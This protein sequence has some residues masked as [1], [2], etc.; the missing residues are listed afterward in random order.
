MDTPAILINQQIMENNLVRMAEKVARTETIQLRPHIKTHKNPEIAKSQLA[1]GA[2]G[3]TVAK[4]GEAEVMIDGGIQDVFLAYPLVSTEKITRGLDLAKRVQRF[5]FS[6]DTV[7]GAERLNYLA[8]VAGILAEVRL[9]INTGLARTGVELGEAVK[10]AEFLGNLK[11][12]KLSGIYTYRGSK[13]LDGEA[14]KDT[15]SAGIEEGTAM[16]ALAKE[17]REAGL[18]ITDVSVGSSLSIEGVLAVEGV[19][20]VRPGTYVF[21][22]AMQVSYGV[23]SQVDCAATVLVTVVSKHANRVVIDG[24]SKAFATDVQ[25]TT[26]PTLI[27]G[28]GSVKGYPKVVFERMN[29]EHG[30]LLLTD[31]NIDVGDRLEIIPNH[32][33]STVNL[34]DAYYINHQQVAVAARGKTQ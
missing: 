25:P 17:L 2:V 7:V 19:T 20:E 32:I 10:F 24:G 18:P 22:D 6:V 27:R 34:Y 5:I 33:C 23:C 13:L 30:V 11:Q 14:T 9:E 15:Y 8:E 28:F 26:F 29:E 31:E 4:L 12:L 3:I 1:H 16:V 21:N